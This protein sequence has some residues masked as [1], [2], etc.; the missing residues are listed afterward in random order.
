MSELQTNLD[1]NKKENSTKKVEIKKIPSKKRTVFT[2]ILTIVA[3]L[4][5]FKLWS[6]ISY[7]QTHIDTDNA[8]IIGHIVPVNAKVAGH[9]EKIF[10]EDNKWVKEGD[11]LVTLEKQDFQVKVNQAKA[12]LETA[13]QELSAIKSSYDLQKNLS[14]IEISQ[15]KMGLTQSVS[16]RAQVDQTEIENQSNVDSVKAQVSSAIADLKV[17]ELQKKQ[18]AENYHRNQ[19]LNKQGAINKQ[20]L[21][22]SKTKL[23]ISNSRVVSAKQKISQL[24]ELVRSSNQK[25]VGIK[26]TKVQSSQ[27]VNLSQE[28]VKKAIVN[29][30]TIK[31]KY[32]QIKAQE[33]RV[34]QSEAALSE[35]NIKLSYTTIKSSVSGLISK[36]NV[37]IGQTISENQSLLSIIPL[38]NRKD[39]WIIANLKETQLKGI[40]IGENVEI[41]VDAYPDLSIEGKVDSI[42]G[43]TGA[44]FSLLPPDNA[45]GNFTK[46]VQRVPVKITFDKWDDKLASMLRPGLSTSVSIYTGK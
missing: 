43:G 28:N 22:D 7:S 38:K 4:G 39:L 29:A 42:G 3:I 45:T 13:K 32:D 36:R 11:V 46:V 31:L 41:K 21:E 10:F 27:D 5:G 6:Y 1:L 17:V 14:Q 35:A 26:N 44:V 16:K 25:V 34:K 37:E 19:D 30:N 23:D 33:A 24:Q 20:S 12:N 15:A 18:D 2:F 8:Y 9:V 40:K